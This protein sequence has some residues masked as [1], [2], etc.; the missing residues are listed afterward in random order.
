VIQGIQL[1]DPQF[2]LAAAFLLI[3]PL[4]CAG[5]ALINTGLGRSRN[6]AH[7]MMSAMCVV[8]VACLVYFICGRS[9]Q[10]SV[11]EQ[12]HSVLIRGK[13]WDWMGAAPAFFAGLFPDAALPNGSA[14][15]LTAWMGMIAVAL[16][17]LIPLG[18][19]AER[20]RLTSI[21]ASTAVLAGWTFPVFAH[22]AWGGGWMAKLG[23]NYGL[24]IGYVDVGGAGVIHATGGMTA[25]A[26]VWILGP[27]RGKYGSDGMPMAIPGHN[28][29]LV[30]LGCLLAAA[31]WLG[32]NGA[33]AILFGGRAV[34]GVSPG[35]A[36]LAAVNTILAAAAGALAAAAIT[37]MRFG[38][39]DASLTANGWVGGLVAVSA[40]S[41]FMPSAAAVLVGLIAGVLVPFS[42]EAIELRLEIDDPGGS[43]SAHAV[44]G[45][46]GVLAAG[47]FGR[48]PGGGA[49]QFLAQL[50][51][52]ATLFGF[53]LP[54]SWG[55]NYLLNRFI[56]CRASREGERQGMDLFELGAGAYPDF[57]TH[58]DEFMPR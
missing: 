57:P 19:G 4:A 52:V 2:G 40:S 34:G 39:P 42:V 35:Q 37:R 50:V 6:A 46:W 18:S 30:L 20:W 45:V 1:S 7:S 9:V 36:V 8:A 47:L 24:G 21:C 43:I 55:A 17:G 27:R 51:G 33:G 14:A 38:M 11:G 41:A 15:P 44:A 5:L 56:P 23:A 32:L 3:A 22:W 49:G 10:G 16:T 31:G 53:V 13:A 28:A 12:A 25:L 48:F 26:M 29:V 54:V 58:P